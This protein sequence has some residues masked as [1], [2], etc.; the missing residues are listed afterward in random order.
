MNNKRKS[1]IIIYL[2]LILVLI[3][4]LV[5]LFFTWSTAFK[6]KSELI[7]NI[8]GP[9]QKWQWQNIGRAWEQGHFS[10]YYMNS[11]LVVFPVV[12]L[13][14]LLSVTNSYG[15]IYFKL[16]FKR[17]L[18][19]I[20]LLGLAVPMEV[21]MIQQYYHMLGLGLLNTRMGLIL[22]QIAM[23]LPFGTFFI[24][25]SLRGLPKALVESA[26]VDGANTW[27]ILWKIIVPLLTPA[28]IAASIF[29]FIWTWNEFL[30][31]LVLISLE[32]LRTL[33]LGMAYFQGK[34]VGDSTL[35][36]MGATLMSFPVIILYVLLQK[37]FISGI[38]TG[39]VK[40]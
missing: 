25:S 40:E 5:P 35:M 28:L 8:F 29:F 30:L 27:I 17:L 37:Y 11:L 20:F 23:S 36:A 22:A 38:V 16:P 10:T 21:V 7:S 9:P 6:S 13:S 14:L 32:K 33:P 15:L 31:A 24:S 19:Q 12:I 18:F 39:S 34:Y 3:L 4:A 2:V 1:L 26:E